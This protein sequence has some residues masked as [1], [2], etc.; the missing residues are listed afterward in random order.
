MRSGG[1][2]MIVAADN[3]SLAPGFHDVARGRIATVVTSLEMGCAPVSIDNDAVP[4]ARV[5]LRHLSP[6]APDAYRRLYR[7]VGQ[8]WLWFSRLRMSDQELAAIL[9]DDLVD[10]F[11]VD[12]EGCE[13]GLLELDF[14]QPESCE[15]AFF[16]LGPALIGKGVGGWLMREALRIAWARPIQRLWVHTCTLDHPGALDFYRRF[17][18]VP[19]M[20][21]VEVIDDPRLDGTLPRE[22]AAHVPLLDGP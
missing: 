16:G 13:D 8:D 10:V 1:G 6:V 9:D 18:F 21:Q 12:H 14:R 15:L 3:H 20:R 4:G 22:A 17:G 11:A 7:H 5:G 2:R 19:F